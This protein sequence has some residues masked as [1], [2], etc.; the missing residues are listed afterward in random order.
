V[1]DTIKGFFSP[2]APVIMPPVFDERYKNKFF[3]NPEYQLEIARKGYVILNLFTQDEV[4]KL[5]DVFEQFRKLAGDLPDTF[6]AS[7]RINI[8]EVR[9]FVTSSISKIID[10]KLK[11]LVWEDEVDVISG[12]FLIKPPTQNSELAPHQDQSLIDERK[13]FAVYG[14]MPLCE[15]TIENGALHVLPGS[16]RLGDL[17]RS[18]TIRWKFQDY[19]EIMKK[20]MVGVPMKPGQMIFFDSALVHGSPPNYTD[21][22][23]IGVNT[24]LKP[25][26][27]HVLNHFK[28]KDT[29]KGK[30][31]TFQVSLDF[32]NNYNIM[33]RPPVQFPR[34]AIE[35]E[36]DFG[37]TEKKFDRLC[38][39]LVVKD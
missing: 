36:P 19:T 15:T 18:L 25:K 9:N 37:L 23:R 28:D 3:K 2:T 13:Y 17:F 30:I 32:F 16:H 6:L 39:Q 38:K 33:E 31:E 7:G 22:W 26:A 14:W 29:P 21:K 35:D 8:P 12:S 10:P 34:I 5:N 24:F 1:F 20:Y 11:E 4:D 27:A